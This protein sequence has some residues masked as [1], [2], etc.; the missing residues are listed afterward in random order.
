MKQATLRIQAACRGF[1]VR[2]RNE[3][4]N[5][6]AA[7]VQRALRTHMYNR[8]AKVKYREFLG[9]TCTTDKSR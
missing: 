9:P 4:L 6:A 2:K 5:K 3:R 7:V 1:V 8:Q